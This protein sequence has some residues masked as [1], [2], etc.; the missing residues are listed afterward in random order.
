MGAN[1]ILTTGPNS[2]VVNYSINRMYDSNPGVWNHYT[3]Q[4]AVKSYD[5][6]RTEGYDTP[7]FH[8]R[9]KKGEIIPMTP[10]YQVSFEESVGS[11]FQLSHKISNG[12]WFRLNSDG[13]G[14]VNSFSGSSPWR[15]SVDQTWIT[16]MINEYYSESF[17]QSAA[18]KIYSSGWDGLTFLAELHK[19]AALF[20]NLVG[21]WTEAVANNRFERLYLESRYGW[22]LLKFDIEEI[23]SLLKNLDEKRTRFRESVGTTLVHTEVATAPIVSS[24]IDGVHT[25]TTDYHVGLRGTVVADIRPPKVAFNPLTT[26]WELIRYSFIIDWVIDVGQALEALS[27]LVLA[28][29]YTA[30]A[31][32]DILAERTTNLGPYSIKSTHDIA[33]YSFDAFAKAQVTKRLPTSVSINPLK[34]LNLDAL[35]VADLVALFVQSFLRRK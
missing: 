4:S 31:G 20:K 23:N 7:N 27:F 28:S 29:D 34:K 21:R 13:S 3:T 12:E 5:Y 30:A 14:P 22:R 8:A 2:N 15:L 26:T 18:A 33:E 35:K 10:F 11:A 32:I 17:V 24:V 19:T 16:D 25:I 6:R 1:R 9:V